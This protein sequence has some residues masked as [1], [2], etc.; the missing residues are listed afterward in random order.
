MTT[1]KTLE[2]LEEYNKKQFGLLNA[3]LLKD[4]PDTK[5]EEDYFKR[6]TQNSQ[7]H[8]VFNS[9]WSTYYTLEMADTLLPYTDGYKSRGTLVYDGAE[10]FIDTPKVNQKLLPLSNDGKLIS[11]AFFTYPK[12][13]KIEKKKSTLQLEAFEL[14]AFIEVD[15]DYSIDVHLKFGENFKQFLNNYYE[16]KNL[17]I[18]VS[19]VESKIY[20]TNVNNFKTSFTDGMVHFNQMKFVL[21]LL[22]IKYDDVEVKQNAQLVDE[23]K[24]EVDPQKDFISGWWSK[25]Y[26]GKIYVDSD[27]YHSYRSNLEK[28]VFFQ[29][30]VNNKIKVGT[31]I[32]FM[33]FDYDINPDDNEFNDKPVIIESFVRKVGDEK[34]VTIELYLNPEWE[35][36]IVEETG[37][38]ANN[39][40]ELYW[41]WT[42]DNTIWTS[43]SVQLNVYP[44]EKKLYIKP[45]LNGIDYKLP[46]I[47]SHNGEIIT[48][49]L[50]LLP[51]GQI[52]KFVSIKI[53]NTITYKSFED[54][55]KF[56]KEI[57]TERINLDANTL[58][59][60]GY[61]VIELNHYFKIKNN[62]TSIFIEEENI[63]VP[64]EKGTKL[65]AYNSL[66]KGIKTI[67]NALEWYGYYTAFKD[68][69][70]M[71]PELSNNGKFNAPS[72]SIF[73]GMIPQLP[74][75]GV[76]AFA[77][78]LTEWSMK[79]QKEQDDKVIDQSLWVDWQNAKNRDLKQY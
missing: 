41:S 6:I 66:Y 37:S 54:I 32:S 72:L 5:Y 3:K 40:I 58:E 26:E 74:Y 44:S 13:V 78:A 49:A 7:S 71:F 1:F 17:N 62:A 9:D 63:E 67:K 55:N 75:A 11:T 28:T 68:T 20:K 69:I 73:V 4:N 23:K 33:L 65:A 30:T 45:I 21:D 29:I 34:R 24:V 59:A 46:E 60:S 10:L 79:D 39:S 31:P 57:F 48:F 38:F 25:D 35:K 77:L 42:Y 2:E 52:K 53:R 50:E 64:V 8:K 15:K 76:Y 36:K 19:S 16:E 18:S 22:D 14:V 51:K 43:K 70:N 56:Y 27:Q 61:K 12:G 47:Y